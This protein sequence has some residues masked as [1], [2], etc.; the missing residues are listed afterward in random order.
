M[1][2]SHLPYG[3]DPFIS[4]FARTRRT[5]FSAPSRPG[6]TVMPSPEALQVCEPH[7]RRMSYSGTSASSAL[8][9]APV[10]MTARSA[11]HVETRMPIG[12]EPF[13]T[14]PSFPFEPPATQSGSMFLTYDPGQTTTLKRPLQ[15]ALATVKPKETKKQKLSIAML[16]AVCADT[17]S[18]R[19][20]RLRIIP[21]CHILDHVLCITNVTTK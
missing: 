9:R 12:R 20:R 8:M 7:I 3:E 4:P 10:M 18:V 19:Y 13:T 2:P 17:A 16:C 21:A 1:Q 11:A 15:S 6:Q 14:S 5:S